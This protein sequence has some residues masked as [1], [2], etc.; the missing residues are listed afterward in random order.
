MHEDAYLTAYTDFGQNRGRY[1][2]GT[3]VNALLEYIREQDGGITI[4]YKDGTP[5]YTISNE[6]GMIDFRGAP[7]VGHSALIGNNFLVTVKHNGS[8]NYTSVV[9]MWGMIMPCDI[10]PSIFAAHLCSVWLRLRASTMQCS[11][12]TGW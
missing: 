7:D 11:G 6:Q 5:T 12:R 2:V 10:L 4:E 9:M 1:V 8:L 3:R